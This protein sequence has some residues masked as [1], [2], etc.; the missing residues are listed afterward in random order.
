MDRAN[1]RTSTGTLGP[2]SFTVSATP[3]SSP[4]L[5]STTTMPIISSANRLKRAAH[6]CASPNVSTPPSFV[7][8]SSSIIGF[9]FAFSNATSR[10]VLHSPTSLS[11]K[12]DTAQLEFM[13]GAHQLLGNRVCDAR[14]QGNF[15]DN[16]IILR[17]EKSRWQ[18]HPG[19]NL[20]NRVT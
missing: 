17:L 1:H 9:T 14:A 2:A 15:Q 12:M 11:G 10:S 16:G 8:V 5:G 4:K 3:F 7:S 18:F 19:S 13:R 6:F 20:C